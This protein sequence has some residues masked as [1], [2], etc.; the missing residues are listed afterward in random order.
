MTPMH[1][2][3]YGDRNPPPIEEVDERWAPPDTFEFHELANIF[4]LLEPGSD[5]FLD[6]VESIRAN[7][8]RE[9]NTMYG[10]KVLD[11]RNRVL[12]CKKAGA[13][14]TPELQRQFRGG[15]AAAKAFVIDLNIHR[16][17][18]NA[19]QRA[20]IAVKLTPG[21]THGGDRRSP[22]SANV[23]NESDQEPKLVLD[24]MTRSDAARMMGV[25]KE[26]VR[27]VAEVSAKVIPAVAEAMDRGRMPIS[28]ATEYA[29]LSKQDQWAEWNSGDRWKTRVKQEKPD[30]PTAK[31]KKTKPKTATLA[32][33]WL[34]AP[35]EARM[36]FMI[37]IALPWLDEQER[38]DALEP[39]LDQAH[40]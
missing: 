27:K 2:Q 29:A 4:P 40:N 34:D 6:L 9:P 30:T 22:V 13:R 14:I 3:T 24:V 32:Q 7:G 33:A 37:E 10:G 18:L 19:V 20:R 21:A 39:D 8:L 15:Y 35:D 5:E 28:K 17:H 36:K 38:G 31:P 11:G 16:R 23:S 12:A 1:D 26:T 25:G